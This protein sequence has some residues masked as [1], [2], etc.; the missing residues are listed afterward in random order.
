LSFVSASW[1]AVPGGRLENLKKAIMTI[2]LTPK[3]KSWN[4]GANNPRWKGGAY[5]TK[6][7]Y[8]K[9]LS[10]T[11]P[12]ADV[13][14]YVCE[15][16]LVMEK[17]LGRYLLPTEVVHH[18]NGDTLDNRPENLQ[19]HHTQ[20]QHLHCSHRFGEMVQCLTCG[21][22]VYRTKSGIRRY[23]FCSQE[24]KRPEIWIRGEVS[25]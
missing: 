3:R 24:C 18:K 6:R 21:R 2:S 15:H 22:K 10:K 25:A 20:G 14:G 5:I 19:L 13:Y 7:G 23:V 17:S 9:V 8:R 16:R 12:Y 11:H 1:L 4:V